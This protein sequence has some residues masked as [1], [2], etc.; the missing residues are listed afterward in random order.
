MK[1]WL[2]TWGVGMASRGLWADIHGWQG[3]RGALLVGL[4]MRGVGD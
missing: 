4:A 3:A 1:G 2:P